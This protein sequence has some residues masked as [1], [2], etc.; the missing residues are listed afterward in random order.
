M[1]LKYSW[2]WV[3]ISAGVID[4][5]CLTDRSAEPVGEGAVGAEGAV[6]CAKTEPPMK[7]VASKSFV[8][9]TTAPFLSP[10]R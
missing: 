1:P 8:V 7:T 9:F 10:Y 6:D 5:R 2:D 3:T 4:G